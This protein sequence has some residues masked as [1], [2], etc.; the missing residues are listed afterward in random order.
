MYDYVIIGAGSAGCVLANRLSEDPSVKVLLLEAG[1]PDKKQEIHVPAAFYK[2][3]RTL[4]DWNYTTE[5]EAY[6]DQRE[7][8]WPRGKVLGG[9]SSINAMIYIRGNHADYDSWRDAGNK[10]W[11]Y[12][13][14]LPYFKK[15]ENRELGPSYYHGSGGPLN[16]TDLRLV[17]PISHAFLEAS[18]ALGYPRNPDFNA[19]SQDGMGIYQVT[20]KKGARF[21]VARA[22]LLPAMRR[23]NLTVLTRAQATRVLFEGARAI[24]VEYSQRGR[25]ERVIAEREVLLSG[26]AINSPQLLML[27]GI[28]PAAE[29]H[30]VG[31][32]VR[33]D[34]PGVGENL[35]D[36]AVVGVVFRS[37]QNCTLDVSETRNNLL[38][39]LLFKK[40]PYTSNIAEAG[41]FIR[42]SPD[43]SSPDI[44]FHFVP[45]FFKDHGA[46][47]VDGCGFTLAPTLLQPAS[48]GR[49]TLRSNDPFEHPRIY[50]NYLQAPEDLQRLLASV[51]ITREI[52]HQKA[53]DPYRGVEY[54]P[55]DHVTND[56]DLTQ[57]I[58]STVETLYHPTSTCKMGQD[59]MAVVDEELRVRGISNLRVVDASIMPNVVRGNTNAPTIMIAEK[60][61]DLIKGTNSTSVRAAQTAGQAQH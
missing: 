57:Y 51:K 5:P 44:Q 22:Y 11:S 3:F 40:G 28:G 47:K 54:L 33:H 53:F 37:T 23:P 16:V 52:L 55:G 19:A 27:S 43:A 42:V 58:R 59:E 6:L 45:A 46:T 1:G 29:L 10:G 4:Y 18:G 12:D 34:L 13:E 17:N 50:A 25:R 35:Q 48:R 15:A 41:G 2:L 36:H 24:G 38:N 32:E 26:G 39:Y 8:Y 21:S 49:I 9:S 56:A 31:I 60:A 61:A 20:Q 14:V 7:L 30:E